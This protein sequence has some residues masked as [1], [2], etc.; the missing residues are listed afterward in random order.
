MAEPLPVIIREAVDGDRDFVFSSWLREYRKSRRIE[1]VGND[2]YYFGQHKVLEDLLQRS[3][4]YV[5]CYQD[6]PKL[7][8][9]YLCGEHFDRCNVV[10]MTFVKDKTRNYDSYRNMGIA[11][12]L[13][14]AFIANRDHLPTFYTHA[15]KLTNQ[16]SSRELRL[17]NELREGG[18]GMPDDRGWLRDKIQD[19]CIKYDPYLGQLTHKQ[20]G[21]E[22]KKKYKCPHCKEL[23]HR[24]Y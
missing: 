18:K 4:T 11:T 20:L 12:I 8:L 14:N 6:D 2:S 7:V 9:G 22:T 10:H 19:L 24:S 23:S 17:R 13:Y 3:N 21:I 5:A 1:D 16:R 15:T